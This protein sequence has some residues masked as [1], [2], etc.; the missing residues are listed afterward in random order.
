MSAS[1]FFYVYSGEASA[2]EV[3]KMII[4][5]RIN[6]ENYEIHRVNSFAQSFDYSSSTW[7]AYY[8]YV[9]ESNKVQFIER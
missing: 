3:T 5:R 2:Y 4:R 8:Q 7:K 9:A 1:D 6:V